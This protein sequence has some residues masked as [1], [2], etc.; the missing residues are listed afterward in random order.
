[1]KT[2][3]EYLEMTKRFAEADREDVMNDDVKPRILFNIEDGK[4]RA[5]A[6][7]DIT[8]DD[9]D[10]D[11]LG[12]SVVSIASS[13]DNLTSM[14]MVSD[15][16]RAKNETKADGSD[17]AR[18]E[19]QAALKDEENPDHNNVSE[20]FM[21]QIINEEGMVV[22]S[23]PYDRTAEGLF[24]WE[25]FTIFRD[26]QGELKGFLPFVM[27]TAWDAPKIL[28]MMKDKFG[29]DYEDLKL[30]LE[31]ARI[32]SLS[33]GVKI[34]VQMKQMRVLIPCYNEEE[35]EHLEHSMTRGPLSDGIASYNQDDLDEIVTLEEMYEAK[36]AEK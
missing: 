7:I 10:R 21:Y 26:T 29:M 22:V 4:P 1:M 12:K 17:W 20:C 28:L 11:A 16:I 32:H 23:L 30:T 31:Q 5:V 33:M 35:Q 24:D 13:I 25:A 3:E 9:D 2:D 36:S 34:V 8:L 15:T 14:V 27:K 6:F 18:G 19:M